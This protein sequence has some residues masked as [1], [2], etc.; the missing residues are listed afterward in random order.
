MKHVVHVSGGLCS[1][2]NVGRVIERFGVA[3]TTFLFADTLAESD[4]LYRLLDET[5][6]HYNIKITRLTRGLT[7]WELFREEGMIGNSRSPI[8]SVKLKRELLD[9]WRIANCD[10]AN[11]VVYIGYDWTEINRLE[12][13]RLEVAPWRIEAP[14]CTW[15]PLWDKCRMGEEL[16]LLGIE[17]PLRYRQGFPHDNCNGECVRAGITQWVKLY[18]VDPSAF[19]HSEIEEQKTI[20]EFQRRGIDTTWA[21]MLKDRRGGTT[22]AMTLTTLRGRIDSGE[23]MPLHEWGGCG[24]GTTN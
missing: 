6:R 20:A 2:W 15:K 17:L 10:P 19:A 12:G 22:K 5:E 9:N 21:T 16:E 24:C 8:C 11:T 23:K 14:M 1:F 3:D 18:E 4:D 7:P 13:L